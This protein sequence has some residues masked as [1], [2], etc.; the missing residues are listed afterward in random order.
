M[1]YKNCTSGDLESALH[2]VNEKYDGNIR[3]KTLEA[4]SFTLT[5]KSSRGPGARRGV[6]GRRI[7]A[8]CWHVHG[9]FF[10]A[11]FEVAPEAVVISG[12][13]PKGRHRITIDGGNWQDWQAGSLYHPAY[14]S[15]LCEC[16]G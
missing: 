3:F 8:A 9:D 4:N 1:K 7:A 6:A 10:D 5:V 2:K 15:E 13:L 11:L 12:Y 16:G 14:A